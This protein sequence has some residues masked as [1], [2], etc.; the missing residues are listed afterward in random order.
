MLEFILGDIMQH[1]EP[2]G[3]FLN[4]TSHPKSRFLAVVSVALLFETG[5]DTELELQHLTYLVCISS[6]LMDKFHFQR[7]INILKAENKGQRKVI[8]SHDVERKA[9]TDLDQE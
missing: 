4:D 8:I 2:A 9:K 3:L 1:V 5:L 7:H 6:G